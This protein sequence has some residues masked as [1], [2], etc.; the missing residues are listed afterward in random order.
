MAFAHGSNDAQKS[1][2]II[3]MALAAY[4]DRQCQPALGKPHLSGAVVGH[5][6]L[7]HGDGAGHLVGRLADHED[8]GPQDHQAAADQ[9]LRRRERPRRW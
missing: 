9:R 3:T 7:R 8:D 5:P 1:M 2:G 6:R 4:A